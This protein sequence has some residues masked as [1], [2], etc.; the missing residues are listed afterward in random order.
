MCL[1]PALGN[2]NQHYAKHRFQ[3]INRPESIRV[4][5]LEPRKWIQKHVPP[6]A[7]LATV[8]H[9]WAEPPIQDLGFKFVPSFLT[10]ALDL[11]QLAKFHPPSIAE[12]E[13]AWDIVM[14]NDFYLWISQDRELRNAGFPQNADKWPPFWKQLAKQYPM[15]RFTAA[16]PN[17]CVREITVYVIHPEILIDPAN[18]DL[19]YPDNKPDPSKYSGQS[20]PTSPYP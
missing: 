9:E 5:R 8:W 6:H 16:V 13:A 12:L 10:P 17:Y 11:E 2:V 1:L 4:T 18:A 15:K 3:A 14:V 19:G 7:R 20:T